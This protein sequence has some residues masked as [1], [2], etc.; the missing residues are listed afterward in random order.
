[1]NMGCSLRDK[2]II[3]RRRRSFCLL[4]VVDLIWGRL[5]RIAT[6]IAQFEHLEG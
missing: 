3:A 6:A 2:R 5:G 1:V 4:D